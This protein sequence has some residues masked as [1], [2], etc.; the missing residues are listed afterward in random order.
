MHARFRDN[1]ALLGVSRQME[2]VQ[3]SRTFQIEDA[4]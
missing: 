2:Q 3:R 1:T 4:Y